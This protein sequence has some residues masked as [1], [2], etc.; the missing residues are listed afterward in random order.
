MQI[1]LQS[2]HYVQYIDASGDDTILFSLNR[3]LQVV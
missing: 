1:S 2:I 3:E